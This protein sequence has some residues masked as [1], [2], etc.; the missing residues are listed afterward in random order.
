M[1]LYIMYYVV[2]CALHYVCPTLFLFYI[3]SILQY[4]CLSLC[5]YMSYI[6]NVCFTSFICALHYVCPILCLFYHFTLC[7]LFIIFFIIHYVS[8][9][10]CVSYITYVYFTLCTPFI[11]CFTL[12]LHLRLTFDLLVRVYM[13]RMLSTCTCNYSIIALKVGIIIKLHAVI[14]YWTSRD[15]VLMSEISHLLAQAVQCLDGETSSGRLESE[16]TA[17]SGRLDVDRRPG[18]CHAV[19]PP[20]L[21]P[22]WLHSHLVFFI[23]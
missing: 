10:L 21:F 13:L 5:H 9:S 8:F 3:L 15:L 14:D 23:M 17:H 12:V 20:V 22:S 11:M 16:H 6:R 7:M 19:L 1:P 18:S 4:V 2:M